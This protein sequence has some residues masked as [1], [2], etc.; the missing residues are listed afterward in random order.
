MSSMARTISRRAPLGRMGSAR[1]YDGPAPTVDSLLWLKK[2]GM[3][4]RM[5]GLCTNV[6][7]S[8]GK[9][10]DTGMVE[11]HCEFAREPGRRHYTAHQIPVGACINHDTNHVLRILMERGNHGRDVVLTD[12]SIDQVSGALLKE[13]DLGLVHGG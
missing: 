10:W 9:W 6:R 4:L 2:L 1:K 11:L 7:V 5:L 13:L 8:A 12:L 3:G